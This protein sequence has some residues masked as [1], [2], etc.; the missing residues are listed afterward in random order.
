MAQSA[1]T[2]QAGGSKQ[3]AEDGGQKSEVR[4]KNF[5]LRNSRAGHRTGQ[6]RA[7]Q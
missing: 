4:G 1:I 5:E 7:S 2:Q 6:E 3:L